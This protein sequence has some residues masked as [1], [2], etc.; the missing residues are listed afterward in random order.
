MKIA[1]KTVIAPN[2]MLIPDIARLVHEGKSVSMT[3][4]GIS[5]LPFIKNK[6][7]VVLEKAGNIRKFDV[8]LASVGKQEYVLHRVVDVKGDRYK[9]MG[10]GNLKE[11]EVCTAADILAVA[12]KVMKNGKAVDLRSDRSIGKAALW[13]VLLPVR[14]W[15]LAVYKLGYKIYE[16]N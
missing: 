14:R 13:N 6:D 8:V 5:M 3:V 15:L 4:K 7:I 2:R 16:K 1:K 10:D 11:C 9:L 12:C